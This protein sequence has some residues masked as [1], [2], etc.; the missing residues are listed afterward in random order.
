MSS[1]TLDDLLSALNAGQ[2]IPY[3]SPYLPVMSA[4]SQRALQLTARINSGYHEPDEVRAVLSEL[5]RETVD[6]SVTVLPP[7]FTEFGPNTHLGSGIFMNIG[8]TFQDQGGIWIGDR[9]FIGHHVT[10]VTQN[11]E[12]DPAHRGDLLPQPVRIGADVWIGSNA[13]ILPG[14]TVGDGAVIGAASVV[15]NDV[16]ARAIVVGSPARVVRSVDG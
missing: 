6:E 14:V 16:P 12:L 1:P 3:D 11:H 8:C 15:T 7:F 5:F 9:T 13:T 2:K 4:T 10:I